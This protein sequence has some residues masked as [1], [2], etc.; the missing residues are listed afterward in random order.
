MSI[1]KRVEGRLLRRLGARSLCYCCLYIIH[2]IVYYP[3]RYLHREI[4][5]M[6]PAMFGNP[7]FFYVK[8][9]EPDNAKR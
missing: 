2:R 1:A 8:D 4:K 7:L 5:R 3:G 6:P 9:N